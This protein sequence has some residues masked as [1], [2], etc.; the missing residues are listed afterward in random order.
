MLYYN[1]F[2]GWFWASEG[3][4]RGEADEE[5]EGEGKGE[6]EVVLRSRNIRCQNPKYFTAVMMKVLLGDLIGSIIGGIVVQIF[7]CARTSN[8][9]LR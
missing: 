5:K 6:R 9:W 8:T 4:G 3:R 7:S 2:P 1:F